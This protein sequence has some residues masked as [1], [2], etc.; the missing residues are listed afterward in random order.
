VQ[1]VHQRF[2]PPL[3]ESP[4]GE[5]VLLCRAR[6]VEEYKDQFLAL[7]CR[8]ADLSDHQLIQI[9]TAGL[10]NPL[11]T[12]VAL[13]RPA[14]LDDAIM[15]ARAY[16]QRMQLHPMDPTPSRGARAHA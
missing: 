2:G 4:L 15:L 16:A 9:Y 13:R 3:T 14:T 1:L 12:D 10:G 7:A 5:L 8:D 11:K 6:T